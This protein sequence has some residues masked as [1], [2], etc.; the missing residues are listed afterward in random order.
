M[1]DFKEGLKSVKDNDFLILL[2]NIT[3]D[4]Y[5][6]SKSLQFNSGTNRF[7]KLIGI[8]TKVSTSTKTTL[9]GDISD[10][11]YL[12]VDKLEIGE[13][14]HYRVNSEFLTTYD[15]NKAAHHL[16]RKPLQ[17]FIKDFGSTTQLDYGNKQGEHTVYVY[18]IT[19]T[20]I[21]GYTINL[22]WSQVEGRCK[23][24]GLETFPVIWKGSR[25]DGGLIHANIELNKRKKVCRVG[26]I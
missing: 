1:I 3:G 4:E 9:M 12:D 26:A 17:K 7:L 16:Q 19:M 2:E 10:Q 18:K 24:L 6:S 13:T 15:N 20:N 14:I 8:P 23:E 25:F 11:G 22:N 21:D 5:V